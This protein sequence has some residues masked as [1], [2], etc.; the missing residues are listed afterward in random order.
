MQVCVAH[1]HRHAVLV[2]VLVLVR[3]Q[4]PQPR[5]LRLILGLDTPPTKSRFLI[6]DQNTAI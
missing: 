1:V 4:P 3:H 6:G 5:A 2:L